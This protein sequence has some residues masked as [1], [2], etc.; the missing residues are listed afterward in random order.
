VKDLTEK[1]AQETIIKCQ[2]CRV[3]SLRSNGELPK[4]SK[5]RED[6]ETKVTSECLFYLLC[7]TKPVH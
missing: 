7:C 6:N 2:E 1:K 3:I 5:F 4:K